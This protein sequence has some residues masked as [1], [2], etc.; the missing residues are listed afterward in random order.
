M[1]MWEREKQKEEFGKSSGP[2][3]WKLVKGTWILRT[4]TSA[5]CGQLS[6]QTLQLP[7]PG[8]LLV[9]WAP[10]PGGTTHWHW[11]LLD[12]LLAFGRLALTGEV[13][14][15]KVMSLAGP[16]EFVSVGVH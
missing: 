14:C 9:S 8:A 4:Q 13:C 5:A 11:P 10:L 7:R 15:T 16:D 2:A 1:E 3:G 6:C 12:F